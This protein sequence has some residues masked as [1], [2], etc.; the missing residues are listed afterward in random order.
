[1]GMLRRFRGEGEHCDNDVTI[2]RYH[3]LLLLITSTRSVGS[4][5]LT[6]LIMKAR[7]SRM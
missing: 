5:V 2:H 6:A 1:M 4:E 7:P 3:L